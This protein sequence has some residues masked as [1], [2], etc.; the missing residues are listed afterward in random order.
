MKT[1]GKL[2]PS[3]SIMRCKVLP[4]AEGHGKPLK[5]VKESNC[6]RNHNVLLGDGYLIVT[7]DKIQLGETGV[8][9]QPVG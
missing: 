8:V 2:M 6:G 7:L 1:K 4:A 5:R 3:L 9:A